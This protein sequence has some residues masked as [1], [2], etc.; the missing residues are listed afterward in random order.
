[1]S[2][3]KL[4]AS[5]FSRDMKGPVTRA[6][7]N[8]ELDVAE[9]TLACSGVFM[10]LGKGPRYVLVKSPCVP[11]CVCVSRRDEGDDWI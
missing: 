1:M 6:I 3:Y 7:Y 4:F 2:I 9:W 8:S 11:V 10:P 5:V